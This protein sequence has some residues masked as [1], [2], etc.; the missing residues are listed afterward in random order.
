M[1]VYA[2]RYINLKLKIRKNKNYHEKS[3]AHWY[4]VTSLLL[5]PLKQRLTDVA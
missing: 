3:T 4:I 5:K 2:K 1:Q